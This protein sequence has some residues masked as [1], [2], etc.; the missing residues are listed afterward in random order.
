VA[1]GP[2][3]GEAY[4]GKVNGAGARHGRGV[5]VVNYGDRYEGE[6]RYGKRDGRGTVVYGSGRR[7][8]GE[9]CDGRE[10]GE[11]VLTDEGGAVL[12]R[13]RWKDGLRCSFLL[14]HCQ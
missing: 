14:F 7:Y 9:W 4:D 8:E 13:G 11:G 10:E 3:E 1:G 2:W 12:F 5:G 6:W